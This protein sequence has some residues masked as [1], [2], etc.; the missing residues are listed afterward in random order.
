MDLER[1]MLNTEPDSRR[2]YAC[3]YSP[4]PDFHGASVILENG[5]EIPITEEMVTESL[6]II[7]AQQN[8][9]QY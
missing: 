2:I 7:L 1:E 6:Q 9:E 5:I 3:I 4:E 8:S